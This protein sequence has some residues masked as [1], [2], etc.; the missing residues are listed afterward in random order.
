MPKTHNIKE[1]ICKNCGKIFLKR[2][3]KSRYHSRGNITIRG[4]RM[5]TCS[6]KCSKG[7][8]RKR[9]LVDFK[10]RGKIDEPILNS[11]EI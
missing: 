4:S 2:N 7:Y 8:S 10:R 11:L 1:E 9:Y 3:E 5:M 6:P